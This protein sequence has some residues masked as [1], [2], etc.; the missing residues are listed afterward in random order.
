MKKIYLSIL[1]SF[2]VIIFG[3][4]TIIDASTTMGDEEYM[5]WQNMNEYYAEMYHMPSYFIEGDSSYYRPTYFN[6]GIASNFKMIKMLPYE[7]EKNGDMLICGYEK[8]P[9]SVQYK[10]S[11]SLDTTIT[12]GVSAT[13]STSVSK[14]GG[15]ELALFKDIIKTSAEI[16]YS[17]EY[18]KE[19]LSTFALHVTYE[20][21]LLYL[22]NEN[23]YDYIYAVVNHPFGKC[24]TMNYEGYEFN[25]KSWYSSS[26][27]DSIDKWKYVGNGEI[28]TPI[29]G[30]ENMQFGL[31][32]VYDN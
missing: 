25:P 1:I 13:F 15:V 32:G 22:N 10:F 8:E 5:Y 27:E 12:V 31:V 19:Q 17:K 30:L 26:A 23:N 21:A 3:S 16:T 9:I 14:S 18:S 4:A 2:I 7:N 11:E 24:Q 29:K 20:D 6:R 28:K